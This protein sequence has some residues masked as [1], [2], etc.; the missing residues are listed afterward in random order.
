MT[1]TFCHI[2]GK[3]TVELF[4]NK[5]RDCYVR[6]KS[7]IT[8]PEISIKV[9]RECLR[10]YRKGRWERAEGEPLEILKKAARNAIE[11]SLKIEM[12]SPTTEII[13][14]D[15]VQASNK[16]YNIGGT[17]RAKGAVSGI[18]AEEEAKTTVKATLELCQNCSRKAGGYFEAI[19]QL[20]GPPALV[21]S[22]APTLLEKLT[23][24]QR[25]HITS[26]KNLKEWTDVYFASTPVAK[27]S[28]RQIL[29]K[30]GGTLKETAHLH[31][32]DKS[33]KNVYRVTILLRLPEFAKGDVIM[34]E[35]KAYQVLG[36]GGAKVSLFDLEKRIRHSTTFKSMEKVER[37]KG[38]TITAV[39]LEAIKG[40]IQ[41]MEQKNYKTMDFYFDIQLKPTDEVKIFKNERVFLLKTDAEYQ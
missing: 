5:C 15:P 26:I 29:E 35:K 34:L 31:T 27:K 41:L 13:V 32:M 38:E 33:G 6:E 19:L 21:K 14:E 1:R 24:E 39:V 2:C 12:E 4:E 25:L 23:D 7:F 17:I 36:S 37:L 3:R 30:F 8:L 16:V 20:R 40:R 28:S 9:C 22:G 10:Y 11:E 18:P